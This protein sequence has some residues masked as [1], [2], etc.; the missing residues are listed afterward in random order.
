MEE[1]W[2]DVKG[3]EGLYQ[4]SNKGQVKSKAR[5]GNWKETILKPSETRD[6]Y[7]VVTLSKKWSSKVKKG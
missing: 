1:I 2:K 5:R 4:I 6:H 7:F 3:Y